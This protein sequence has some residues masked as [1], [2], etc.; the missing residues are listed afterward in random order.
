MNDAIALYTEM[1]GAVI[2]YVVT[3]CIGNLIVNSILGAAFKGRLD[4]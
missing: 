3:F 2:P 4:F 1:I